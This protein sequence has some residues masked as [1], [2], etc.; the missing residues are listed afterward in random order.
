MLI[1]NVIADVEKTIKEAGSAGLRIEGE[2]I[3]Q[4]LKI[5]K[6]DMEQDRPLRYYSDLAVYLGLFLTIKSP[7]SSVTMMNSVGW[8]TLRGAMSLGSIPSAIF[9]G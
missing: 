6:E 9:T 4:E 1:T 8:A 2:R 7:M 5:L 3:L